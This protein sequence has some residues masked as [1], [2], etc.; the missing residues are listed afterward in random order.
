M[1]SVCYTNDVSELK[2]T[3]VLLILMF[4]LCSGSELKFPVSLTLSSPPDLLL[5]NGRS[6][7]F[8]KNLKLP[9]SGVPSK[10]DFPMLCFLSNILCA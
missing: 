6:D 8:F 3:P 1:L 9:F 7:F 10:G 5:A 4:V 2:Q